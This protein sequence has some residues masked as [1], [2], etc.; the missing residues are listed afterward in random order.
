M[1]AFTGLTVMAYFLDIYWLL[2]HIMNYLSL[3]G[4][5]QKDRELWQEKGGF[6][7]GIIIDNTEKY[8]VYSG[9]HTPL[10]II[11]GATR[12]P[13]SIGMSII[14]DTA[15]ATMLKF[16][17]DVKVNTTANLGSR[18]AGNDTAAE[19][20]VSRARA[21]LEEQQ[22]QSGLEDIASFS[23]Q[24]VLDRRSASTSRREREQSPSVGKRPPMVILHS[25]L[26]QS[27]K[28][29][30]RKSENNPKELINIMS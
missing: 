12:N 4:R 2:C 23:E 25:R 3:T 14:N 9:S 15:M 29:F 13:G 21:D 10:G 16:I 18:R 8:I 28:M 30:I 24:I 11:D 19:K 5:M 20:A 26:P 17:M 6:G 1:Q 27:R 7:I 22:M